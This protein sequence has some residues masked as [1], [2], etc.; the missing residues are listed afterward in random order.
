MGNGESV[1]SHYVVQQKVREGVDKQGFN[2]L[3]AKAADAGSF[4]TVRRGVDT[5]TQQPRAIKNIQK[6]NPGVR[7]RVQHE[8][9]M[10][11]AVSGQCSSIVEFI[12]YFEESGHFDLVFEFCSNGTLYEAMKGKKMS[13]RVAAG[14]CHQLLNALA[15]I[16]GRRVLHRDVKPAN[17]LLKDEHTTKLADFGSAC[18]LKDNEFLYLRAGTPAFFPPEVDILP[19]GNGYS[20]PADVWAAGIT[21]YMMLFQGTHP[22]I[23]GGRMESRLLR[24][25][26][27]DAGMMWLWNA[28]LAMFLRWLMMPCPQQRIVPEDACNHEWLATYGHGSGVFSKAT[29]AKLVPD[30]YGRWG[31]DHNC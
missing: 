25:G 5:R 14:F 18:M 4:G 3:F 7:E 19:K 11:Q 31:E 29:P 10:M 2:S 12:E 28:K 6:S 15:Y 17:I 23:D 16:K 13:E 20:F 8:I 22:F 9:A 26:S 21:I 24:Q 1:T 30:S 27:F